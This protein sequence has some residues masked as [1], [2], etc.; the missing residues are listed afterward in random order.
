LRITCAVC[1]AI[2]FVLDCDTPADFFVGLPNEG[3]AINAVAAR[4][5]MKSK[6]LFFMNIS[7][8]FDSVVRSCPKAF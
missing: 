3:E 7:S 8:S 5:L 4:Q 2:L 6:R 1:G